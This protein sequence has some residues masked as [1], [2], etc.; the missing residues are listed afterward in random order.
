MM[1]QGQKQGL[2][3]RAKTA[4]ASEAREKQYAK[5][6]HRRVLQVEELYAVRNERLVRIQ[7]ERAEKVSSHVLGRDSENN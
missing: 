5:M 3:Q 6:M 7:L 4:R 1:L 2:T